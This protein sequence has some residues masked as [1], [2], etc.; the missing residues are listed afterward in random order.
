[1]C[2][3]GGACVRSD[4]ENLK[5]QEE[6]KLWETWYEY[7]L[8]QCCYSGVTMVLQRCYNGATMFSQWCSG[9]I[10]LVLQ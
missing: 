1:V 3:H 8:T 4:T 6:R 5:W 9:G 2:I 10:T 7:I